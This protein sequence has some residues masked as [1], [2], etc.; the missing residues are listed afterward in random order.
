M[1]QGRFTSQARIASLFAGL[2]LGAG[3]LAGG[4]G[5]VAADSALASP[6]CKTARSADQGY[7]ARLVGTNASDCLR[8]GNR[9]D[10]IRG[11]R[12]RDLLDGGPGRD[13]I[14][15]RD[16]ARDLVQCGTG[17]D[18]VL[19]DTKDV[20]NGCETERVA[21]VD[22]P[23]IDGSNCVV[24][25]A[26]ITAS[27]C[28]LL[29]SD[30]ADVADPERL[31]GSLSCETASRVQRLSGG[32]DTHLTAMGK[33]AG[34]DFFRRL[35]V[36][37][38][39]DYYGERCELGKNE[40]RYGTEDSS[41]TFMTYNEGQHRITFFS[42]K[43]TSSLPLRT[44]NWQTIAQMKQAQP[45]AN[46]GGSPILEVQLR[47]GKYYLDSPTGEYWSTDAQAGVWARMAMDVNYSQD[48]NRGSVTMYIDVNGDGDAS[49]PGEQSPTIKTAT[50]K[51]ETVGGD[52]ADGVAPGESI[53][54]HLRLGVYHDPTIPC[55]AG[56]AVDV[57]N[58]EVVN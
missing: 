5:P 34:N 43:L 14:S 35:T 24:D 47:N 46:G 33:S 39:D 49:D 27:G 53:P 20:L 10:R 42:I 15:A 7:Q 54:S 12:G 40:H 30:T 11:L 32:G 28:S 8:G 48:P 6:G 55:V 31:W 21:V 25:P 36:L 58:I 52:A 44:Q 9:R 18:L 4:S 16:G 26:T 50:L 1:H 23:I 38:G 56:C 17:D 37:D 51:P 22:P 41:G 57:D 19:A 13:R 2:A 3:L 45:S 29:K